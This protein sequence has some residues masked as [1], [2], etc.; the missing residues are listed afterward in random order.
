[1]YNIKYV[2]TFVL[3]EGTGNHQVG[4]PQT[5]LVTTEQV[6]T[7]YEGRG[8]RGSHCISSYLQWARVSTSNVLIR[9]WGI[10]VSI[11]LLENGAIDCEKPRVGYIDCEE[12]SGR[13]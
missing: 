8:V 2:V 9:I 5:C 11:S 12:P 6:T 10:L 7:E 1:M 3:I 4:F 13:L